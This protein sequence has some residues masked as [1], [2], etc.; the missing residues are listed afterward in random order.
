MLWSEGVQM[1]DASTNTVFNMRA[2]LLWTINDFPARGS[3]PGWSGQGYLACPT[4]NADTSSIHF[5]NKMSYVGHRRFLHMNHKWR[6]SLLFNGQPERRLHPRRFSNT[7]IL[8]QLACLPDRIPGKHPEHGGAT[9]KHND[10]TR[11]K[12]LNWM[13]RSI[14][15][16]LEYWSSLE[17]KHNIYF[18]HVVKNVDESFVNT[19]LMNEKTKDKKEAREDLKNMGIRPHQWPKEKVNKRKKVNNNKEDNKKKIILSHADYSFKPID[20][21]RFCQF[22]KGVRLPDG[23]GS[24]F[25][26]KVNDTAS[27]LVGLKSHDHHILMQRLLPIGAQAFLPENVSTT[28]IDLCT[29]FKKIYAWSLAVND[30]RNARKEVVKILCNLELIYPP[31]FF[32]IMIHLILHLP[33]EAILG[34]HVHM[35]WMYPFERYMKKLKNYVRNKAKPKGSIAEGYVVDEALT[36]CSMYLEGM[37][38]KFNHVDRNEDPGLPKSEFKS[39]SPES[40]L[41]TEFSPWFKR[42]IY[43]LERESPSDCTNEL[44]ALAH[45]PL[46]ATSYT[47]CIVNGVRFVVL[48]HDLQRTT[49]NSGILTLGVDGTPFYG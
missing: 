48:S 4:C 15:F 1:R 25:N 7:T 20:R 23:F 6:Q 45:G 24:N 28:I 11:K 27:N 17:L 42:K 36:F 10:E 44:K 26:K 5:T 22:I 30:M 3:L 12:E 40:D 47:A 33:E 16:E 49:Q 18:M 19:A 9:R 29:F 2:M 35:R 38:T 46:D 13:K 31:A 32:D 37:Q 14:F 43:R 41:K 34:G 21:Q 8:K 39:E